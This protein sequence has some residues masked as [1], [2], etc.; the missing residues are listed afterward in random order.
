MADVAAGVASETTPE[1]SVRLLMMGIFD[2]IQAHPWVGA[3][4][5]REPWQTALLEIFFEICSRLQVLGVAEG[6]LFDAASTLLSYLLG[7]A[8][9]YAAG[10]SLS[11]HTD[12]A[13]FL[14]AAVED[15]LDRRESSDH[16]F[17]RQVTRLADHDDRDQFIAGVEVILDGVMTRSR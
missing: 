8:S 15:W 10:V 4:L 5:A 2:A 3:Q 1:E 13:A 17:V 12:R 9:Q 11:R 14:S 16:P 7:V 6:E